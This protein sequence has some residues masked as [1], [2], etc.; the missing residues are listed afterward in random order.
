MKENNRSDNK[1]NRG[2][3]GQRGRNSNSSLPSPRVLENYENI[4]PGSTN[5]LIEI[6]KKEQEH[7]HSW[8]DKYLKFHNFSYRGGMI[9]SFIYNLALLALIFDLVKQGKTS[10]ALKF[11]IINA[12][13][14]AFAIVVTAVERK[15]TTRKP[16]RRMNQARKNSNRQPSSGRSSRQNFKHPQLPLNS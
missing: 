15:V 1:N 11:F 8:Q 9:F 16:P 14:I 2:N 4:A 6:A 5:K 12:A 13:L 3:D 7:R 10:L